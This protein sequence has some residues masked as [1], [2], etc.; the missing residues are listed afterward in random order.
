M[1]KFK[2]V[3]IYKE[4]VPHKSTLGY[5]SYIR[6]GEK[7]VNFD[8]EHPRLYRTK[9]RAID[10]AEKLSMGYINTSPQYKVISVDC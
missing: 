1:K 4:P 3:F 2:I 7:Y 6:D 10:S 8:E 9:K 5:G